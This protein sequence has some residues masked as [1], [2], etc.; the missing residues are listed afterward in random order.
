MN[1]QLRN[2]PTTATAIAVVPRAFVVMPSATL[3]QFSTVN[4]V[5]PHDTK[6]KPNL[7]KEL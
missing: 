5:L 2:E 4:G 7:Y 1:L 6:E 3:W